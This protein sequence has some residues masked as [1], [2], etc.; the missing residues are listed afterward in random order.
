MHNFVWH[1]RWTWTGAPHGSG[2]G[3]LV[4]FQLSNGFVS[5]VVNVSMTTLLTE[6][7]GMPLLGANV[8]AVAG[9]ALANYVSA[10]RF[11][12]GK[13]RPAARA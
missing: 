11:V 13:E 8:A 10:T 6:V 4:R 3:R 1:E 5:L 7:A 9:C 2:L 12:Y